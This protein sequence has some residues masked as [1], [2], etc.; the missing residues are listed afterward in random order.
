MSHAR[1]VLGALTAAA[2]LAAGCGSSS[3]KDEAKPTTAAAKAAVTAPAPAAAAAAPQTGPAPAKATFVVR[4]D[5]VCREARGL[6]QRANDAV[7]KAFAAKDPAAAAD[8][9]DRYLPIFA[10]HVQSVKDLRR[11]K[12]DQKV[13]AGLLK[14]MDGQVKALSAQ[15]KALRDGDDTL[16]QQIGAAQMQELAFA[17]ELG[18]QYGFKVCGRTA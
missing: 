14:V 3:N 2:L 9:I 1:P 11:P 18:K 6:S 16:L 12:G 17:E 10:T 7:Q 4:A 13:L 8:A 5:R 15:S